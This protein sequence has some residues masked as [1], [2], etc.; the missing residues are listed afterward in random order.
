MFL[1]K[2]IVKRLFIIILLSFTNV[3]WSDDG[4][5]IT[6]PNIVSALLEVQEK[7]DSISSSVM[8]CMDSRKD[9]NTCMCDN[10]ALM[11][12]FNTA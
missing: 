10:E 2:N 12:D 3:A 5:D 7:I 1:N 11:L 4:I 9:H 8:K 6:D